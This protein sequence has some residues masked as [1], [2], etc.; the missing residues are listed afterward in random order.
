MSAVDNEET[1][2]TNLCYLALG[3]CISDSPQRIKDTYERLVRK[4]KAEFTSGDPNVRE[5][6]RQELNHIETMYSRIVESVSYASSITHEQRKQ[7]VT[8]S[9]PKAA[10]RHIKCEMTA[11]PSCKAQIIKGLER[12]PYCKTVLLGTWKKFQRKYLTTTNLLLALIA[13]LTITLA[14]VLVKDNLI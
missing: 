3:V 14:V 9:G 1:L 13:A 11:C 5:L 2:D 10:V 8:I 6:A 7:S 12:C 4:C